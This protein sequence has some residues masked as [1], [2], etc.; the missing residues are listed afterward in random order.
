MLRSVQAFLPVAGQLGDVR[1]A[2]AAPPGRWLPEARQV[3]PNR[4]TMTVRAGQFTRAVTAQISAPWRAGDTQWRSLSWD[5]IADEDAALPVERFLPSLDGELGLNFA[6]DRAT[7]VVDARYRPPGGPAG[8]ALD[9]VVLH[10]VAQ[11]T[12][13]RLLADIAA[14]LTAEALLVV[15]GDVLV[16][17]A[18]ETSGEDT[19]PTSG[20]HA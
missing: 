14:R 2:F 17:H 6:D 1:D 3:G 13:E 19:A 10:R 15:P 20:E 5:P 4:W 7:L 12:L 8:A 16:P 9:S 18:D 11:R